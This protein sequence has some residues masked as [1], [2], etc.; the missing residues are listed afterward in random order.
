[1]PEAG[2]L[3]RNPRSRSE[4]VALVQ[5]VDRQ[6]VQGVDR[7]PVQGVGLQAVQ[8]MGMLEGRPVRRVGEAPPVDSSVGHDMI[9]TTRKYQ[10]D[11]QH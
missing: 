5:G 3:E 8:R 10:F 6:P 7:Q 2:V 4:V 11:K 9:L 1:M